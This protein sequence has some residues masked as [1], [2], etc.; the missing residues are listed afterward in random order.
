MNKFQRFRVEVVSLGD[1]LSDGFTF[2]RWFH[3]NKF[4]RNLLLI[5]KA[6]QL[7]L[8]VIN[9]KQIIKKEKI[10]LNIFTEKTSDRKKTSF[11][12]ELCFVLK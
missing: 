7:L 3:T 12:V 4:T 5:F 6:L 10:Y 1:L 2:T 11:G 9:L 8:K